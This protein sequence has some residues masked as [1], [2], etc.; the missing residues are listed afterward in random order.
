MPEISGY[1]M[2]DPAGHESSNI[3]YGIRGKTDLT[4]WMKAINIDETRGQVGA[5]DLQIMKK[6]QLR[7]GA[8]DEILLSLYVRGLTSPEISTFFAKIYGDR[9]I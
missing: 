2:H 9:V 8:V 5:F 1:E 4:N 7:L 3:R 6:R